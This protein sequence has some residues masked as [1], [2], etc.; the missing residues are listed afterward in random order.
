MH[1]PCSLCHKYAVLETHHIFQGALRHK[2]E[3]HGFTIRI[4][5]ACHTQG[6][7]SVHQNRELRLKLKQMAQVEF[8]LTH[9]REQFREIFGK[10]YLE[11]EEE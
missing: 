5:H 2:S 4:C 3:V 8:E 7:N 6:P 10:N 9:T 1:E 11:L